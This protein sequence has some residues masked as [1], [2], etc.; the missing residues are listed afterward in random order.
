MSSL[1]DFVKQLARKANV[2]V[3]TADVQ[4]IV[5]TLRAAG[6]RKQIPQRVVS[7][8]KTIVWDELK[9]LKANRQPLTKTARSTQVP[10]KDVS[11]AMEKGFCPRCNVSMS[12]VRL[13]SYEVALFCSGCRAT[14]W[15]N[16]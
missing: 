14:L 7:A 1:F 15:R 13:R 12:D 4:K 5:G 10:S 11:A 8:A 6:M 16:G 2:R 3:S 9:E